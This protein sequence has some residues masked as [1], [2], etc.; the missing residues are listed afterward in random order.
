M[1]A[2]SIINLEVAFNAFIHNA[3]WTDSVVL[4][5]GTPQTYIVPA[6]GRYLVFEGN[7]DFYA[8]WNGI[9]AAVPNSTTSD[10]SASSM[11]P[12]QRLV[13]AGDVISLIS[14]GACILTIDVY[15]A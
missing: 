13:K 12:T 1:T 3:K 11:N 8:N 9:A 15:G 2:P 7:A 4:L 5:A 10:G 6:G 14:A